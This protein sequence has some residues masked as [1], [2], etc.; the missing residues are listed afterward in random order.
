MPTL[1]D[2]P[3]LIPQ[4][5]LIGGRLATYT[6]RRSTRA[7]HPSIQIHPRR[8]LEIVLPPD[9]PDTAA[10]KLLRKETSW[11]EKHAGAVHRA[12][13]LPP[14]LETGAQLPVRGDWCTLTLNPAQ[15]PHVAR[16]GNA[17][18]V[19]LPHPEDPEAVRAQL[20]RW[21]RNLARRIL[22]QRVTDLRHPQ[23]PP[24]TTITVRDQQT[25]WASC[26]SDESHGSLS[27]NWRLVM[28]LPTVMDAI[29]VHELT[30]LTI[31]DHSRRFWRA[32]DQRFPQHRACRRWLNHNGPRLAL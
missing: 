3:A 13:R 1:L 15:A 5:L 25:L 4:P 18:L 9:A 23:E 26:S 10:P 20:E 32:M 8:G 6:I 24:V 2:D 7:K 29:V 19:S 30:H 28:A 17:L 21:Y 16:T 14:E 27:F 31:P 11:L 12:G 22:T